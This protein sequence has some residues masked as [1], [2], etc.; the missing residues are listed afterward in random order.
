[1]AGRDPKEGA[2]VILKFF[3]VTRK[4]VFRKHYDFS[5]IWF[6]VHWLPEH[7]TTSANHQFTKFGQLTATDPSERAKTILQ[8]LFLTQRRIKKKNPRGTVKQRK[9]VS[10]SFIWFWVRWFADHAP[11]SVKY[12]FTNFSRLS[13]RDPR[14]GVKIILNL[15]FLTRRLV[16]RKNQGGLLNRETARIFYIW[17]WVQR[18]AEHA[19]KSVYRFTKL[20]RLIARDPKEGA[21]ILLF[22]TRRP[23][24]R[25]KQRPLWKEQKEW[26]C[27]IF[28]FGCTGWQSTPQNLLNINLS[29]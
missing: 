5:L 29:S 25:R 18:L 22:L 12:I 7:A 24:L 6:C 9:T 8:L 14:E 20:V 15:H 19:P 11:K 28:D 10:K 26:K 23:V 2:K 3:F 17:F 27:L 21:K 4:Q 1:M 16:L 13:G